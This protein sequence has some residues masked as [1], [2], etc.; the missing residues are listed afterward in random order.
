[1][2]QVPSVTTFVVGDRLPWPDDAPA[3]EVK[4]PFDVGALVPRDFCSG[5]DGLLLSGEDPCGA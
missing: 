3:T 2:A 4:G 1:M 5:R